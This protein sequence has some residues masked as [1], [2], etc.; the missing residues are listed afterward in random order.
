[1]QNESIID[2]VCSI[3][4]F[5]LSVTDFNVTSWWE[6]IDNDVESD[7][8]DNE[9]VSETSN[10][11]TMGGWKYS[12]DKN[13]LSFSDSMCFFPLEWLWKAET[14]MISMFKFFAHMEHD[15]WPSLLSNNQFLN[16][17]SF[18]RTGFKL[19]LPLFVMKLQV[20]WINLRYPNSDSE[21]SQCLCIKTIA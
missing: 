20:I 13:W 10:E 15:A 1:M 9:A 14:S 4:A 2:K 3:S 18:S 5:K 19:L 16:L 8:S 12:E 17:G 11:S 7:S 6:N 21:I